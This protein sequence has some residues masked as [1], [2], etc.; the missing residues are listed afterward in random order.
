VLVWRYGEGRR[1][2]KEQQELDQ[3]PWEGD[4]AYIDK[5][6][7]DKERVDLSIQLTTFKEVIDA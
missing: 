7:K 1:T 2:Q 5:R 6:T 3:Y 4:T